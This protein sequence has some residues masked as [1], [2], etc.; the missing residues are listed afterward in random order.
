MH[1]GI[2]ERIFHLSKGLKSAN[3]IAFTHSSV[4][5]EFP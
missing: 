3:E 5:F 1:N 2:T 4:M